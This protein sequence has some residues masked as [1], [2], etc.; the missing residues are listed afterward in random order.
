MVIEKTARAVVTG[1]VSHLVT[2][3]LE[4]RHFLFKSRKGKNY[5]LT[6][7]AGDH[8]GATVVRRDQPVGRNRIR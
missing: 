6:T 3:E 1:G 8:D 2:S 4:D 5:P 7:Y